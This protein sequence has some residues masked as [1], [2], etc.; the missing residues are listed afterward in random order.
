MKQDAICCKIYLK[1]KKEYSVP[2]YR[3]MISIYVGDCTAV[4]K[5]YQCTKK[6]NAKQGNT[7]S[8]S[9]FTNS[10]RI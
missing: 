7:F 3:A 4:K 5:S 10:G 9:R 1:N 2:Y 6:N 8:L